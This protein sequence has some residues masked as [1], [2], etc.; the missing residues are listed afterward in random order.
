MS[1]MFMILSA[2]LVAILMVCGLASEV[3]AQSSSNSG[4][5]KPL[6]DQFGIFHVPAHRRSLRALRE[7]GVGWIR[8][9]LQMGERKKKHLLTPLK[10]G[11]GLWLTLYHRDQSNVN[12]TGTIGFRQSQRGGFPPEDPGRYQALVQETLSPLVQYLQNQGKSPGEWLIIQVNNE[13]APTDIAPD[14]PK[15]FWHGTGDQYLDTLE[16]AYDAVKAVDPTI[17]VAAAGFSS[18]MMDLVLQGEPRVV[19]WCERL[20]KK[21]RFDWADVHLRHAID[22]IPSKVAWIRERWKG[23]LGSTEFAGPDERTGTVYSEEVQAEELTI[24]M[25]AAFGAGV[26]RIFWAGLVE[27]DFSGPIHA[28][29]GLL[30]KD[31]WRRKPVF[32]AYR[33][34]IR[35]SIQ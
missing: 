26:D 34:F 10:T 22:T 5:Y 21:G 31:T 2:L 4:Q 35:S 23:P 8:L 28:K 3:Q 24:R 17:P 1:R 25:D 20:L 30:A 9:Q 27:N 7:L 18:G 6:P 15:R 32:D 33:E 11:H 13:V 14:K 16:L 29:E 12:E 19:N